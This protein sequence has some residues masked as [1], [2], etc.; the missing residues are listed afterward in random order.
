MEP[1]SGLLSNLHSSI[2][3]RCPNTHGQEEISV[4]DA[5][6]HIKVCRRRGSYTHSSNI[7]GSK[8]FNVN[9]RV[10]EVYDT[11]DN[12]CEERKEDKI[13]VMFHKL[14]SDFKKS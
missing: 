14:V 10:G 2:H 7:H 8:S 5:Q 12:M 11:F 4:G 3:V 13:Q 9:L 1:L 6:K